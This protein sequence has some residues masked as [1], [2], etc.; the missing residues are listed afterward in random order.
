[1]AK[2]DKPTKQAAP[3]KKTGGA[4]AAAKKSATSSPSNKSTYSPPRFKMANQNK[5]NKRNERKEWAINISALMTNGCTENG[6]DDPKQY[7]VWCEAIP[8]VE[9]KRGTGFDAFV[10]A[11]CFN[12]ECTNPFFAGTLRFKDPET[13]SIPIRDQSGFP[14]KAVIYQVNPLQKDTPEVR[15]MVAEAYRQINQEHPKNVFNDYVVKDDFDQTPTGHLLPMS[16]FF[17]DRDIVQYICGK[18][19][20]DNSDP[21]WARSNKIE[22]S[23]YFEGPSY[24]LN[25]Q[26]TLGYPSAI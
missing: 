24:P 7:A 12:G 9:G 6:G 19:Q 1:M 21:T 14:C 4:K 20:I 26:Y 25:A 15:R 3:A 10:Q 2:D 5:P 18:H 23:D 13:P 8:K 11:D 16:H 22:S 17:M